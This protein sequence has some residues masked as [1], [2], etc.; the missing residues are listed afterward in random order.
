MN[1]DPTLPANDS[2]QFSFAPVEA[3]RLYLGDATVVHAFVGNFANEVLRAYGSFLAGQTDAVVSKSQVD[4]LVHEYGEAFM[5][6]DPRY[7]I[8]PWQG[9][10]MRGKLLAA[11]PGMKGD[12]DPGAALFGF[13]A[14]QCVKAALSLNEGEDEAMVGAMLKEI[15]DDVRGRILGVI[16]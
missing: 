15:L 8:A 9:S 4:A 16:A 10:R 3:V 2:E 11:L 6:K 13:L 14:L 1:N 12:D 7:R 5:G